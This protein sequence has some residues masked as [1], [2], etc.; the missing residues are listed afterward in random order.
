MNPEQLGDPEGLSPG[1]R[2]NGSGAL[3]NLHPALFHLYE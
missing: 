2:W 1:E 3:F